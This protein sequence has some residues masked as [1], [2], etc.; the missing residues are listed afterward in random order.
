MNLMKTIA[1]AAILTASIAA[2]ALAQEMSTGPNTSFG[3][4]SQQRFYQSY[5]QMGPSVAPP[6]SHAYRN[7]E[8]F[9]FSGR[10]RSRVGGYS[11]NL[12]PPG[13]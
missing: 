8:N 4:G 9:G 2:P 1:A 12:N 5:D 11:P 3:S 6:T 10:D 13:T 7:L